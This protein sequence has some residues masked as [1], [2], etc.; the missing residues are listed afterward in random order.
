MDS[1]LAHFNCASE[2]LDLAAL[3]LR[4]YKINVFLAE[5]ITS[6]FSITQD[7]VQTTLPALESELHITTNATTG[8]WDIFLSADE[9]ARDFAVTSRLPRELGALLLGCRPSR[10]DPRALGVLASIV[11]AKKRSVG[12]VLESNGIE[13]RSDLPL[14]IREGA[15]DDAD[16]FETLSITGGRST[17]RAVGGATRMS[18]ESFFAGGHWE[19]PITEIGESPDTVVAL[20]PKQNEPYV[21]LLEQV[22][23]EARGLL[24]FPAQGETLAA[25]TQS[26]HR[27]SGGEQQVWRRMCG[28][29]GELFVGYFLHPFPVS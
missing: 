14:P 17:S 4:L 6:T 27:F 3:C 19:P 1:V 16:D 24:D 26:I 25:G 8:S 22:V 12:R 13:E 10:V 2:S 11:H 20:D 29:A 21:R 18:Q 9:D 23:Q 7:G 5:Q 15:D 28:C